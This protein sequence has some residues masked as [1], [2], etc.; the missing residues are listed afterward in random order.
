MSIRRLYLRSRKYLLQHGLKSSIVRL[1]QATQNLI[2]YNRDIIFCRDLIR[3]ELKGFAMP[4]NFR[5]E[6]TEKGSDAAEELLKRIAEDYPKVLL[7][8]NFQKRFDMGASLWCLKHDTEYAGYVWI[9]TGR[10]PRPWYLPLLGHDVYLFDA[11]AFPK[12][13]RRGLT[14][15]MLHHILKYYKSEG[16]QRAYLETKE[17]NIII[18]KLML[19]SEFAR[20]GL[21]KRRFGRVTYKVT[22]YY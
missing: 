3:G 12:F 7:Q 4:E 10:T 8:E 17:W 18:I 22:W 6:K 2:F 15:I 1:W 11:L 19:K 13:R 9:L 20:I 5:I 16:F 14:P 21:A